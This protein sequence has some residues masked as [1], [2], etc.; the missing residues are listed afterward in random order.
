MTD[1]SRSSVSKFVGLLLIAVGMI[2]LIL[3]LRIA[4]SQG[5]FAAWISIWPI[6]VCIAMGSFIL[7]RM[8]LRRAVRT[9]ATALAF[10]CLGALFTLL[11]SQATL[12][13]C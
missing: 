8:E 7:S 2:L 10:F 4:P 3:L 6:A 13:R 5:M 9:T 12:H 11:P 1:H